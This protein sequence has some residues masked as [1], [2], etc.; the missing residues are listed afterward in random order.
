MPGKPSLC[1]FCVQTF[2]ESR[3]NVLDMSNLSNGAIRSLGDVTT[4]K[5]LTVGFNNPVTLD[6]TSLTSYQK[7][8]LSDPVGAGLLANSTTNSKNIKV[9][10]IGLSREGKSPEARGS[11]FKS[12]DRFLYT[13]LYR[14]EVG[15]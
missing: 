13:N 2:W 5:F 7:F 14:V 12:S 3:M 15:Q 11:S 1:S 8:A 9:F 6:T 4:S 10:E